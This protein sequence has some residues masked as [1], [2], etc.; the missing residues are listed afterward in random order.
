[1][2]ETSVVATRL[3][4]TVLML[5][6]LALCGVS[7]G[8]GFKLAPA[9]LVFLG[10]KVFFEF[11]DEQL[12]IAW[13]MLSAPIILF[14]FS[15]LLPSFLYVLLLEDQGKLHRSRGY[16]LSLLLRNVKNII[17]EIDIPYFSPVF[18]YNSID[19]FDEHVKEMRDNYRNFVDALFTGIELQATYIRSPGIATVP[20]SID[21][22]VTMEGIN[23]KESYFQLAK[24]SRSAAVLILTTMLVLFMGPIALLFGGIL[25]LTTMLDADAPLE[26]GTEQGNKFKDGVYRITNS[27]YGIEI[28]R[29]IGVAHGGVM[30]I[31]YHVCHGSRLISGKS[32]TG[33]YQIA[34][35]NDIVTYGGPPNMSQ[36]DSDMMVYANCETDD[37]RVS[38][39]VQPTV[40]IYRNV[41]WPSM[42]KPGESGSPLYAYKD[43]KLHLLGLCGRY[44]QPSNQEAIEFCPNNTIIGE[45]DVERIV[46]HPGSGKTHKTLPNII[47]ARLPNLRGKKILV[48]GPTRVVCKEIANSL[49]RNFVVGVNTSD[50]IGEVKTTAQVQVAAHATAL[51]MLCNEDRIMKNVGLII[52]DEAH[53]NDVNTI[54]LRKYAR[55][56]GIKLVEMSA[57][58]DGEYA[59]DSNQP[60]TD[61]E[62]GPNKLEATLSDELNLGHRVMV[63]VSGVK[64]RM[65]D[66]LMFKYRDYSPIILSRATL[67]PAMA[68]I[69]ALDDDNRYKSRLII[70]TDIAEC[71]INIPDLDVVIDLM[72]K[73]TYVRNGCIISG[74]M[75]VPSR[76]SQ[77]QRRGRVGRVKK[78][79]YYYTRSPVDTEIETAAEFDATI[80]AS[81]RS[82]GE[83]QTNEW[84]IKLTD[85]QFLKWLE[86]DETPLWTY[87][88]TGRN[89][90]RLNASQL[91][92][93][94][95]DWKGPTIYTG[96]SN[97]QCP[98]AGSYETYDERNHDKMF[99]T[100]IIEL[101]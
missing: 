96:C 9:I 76:A 68:G 43:E 82:W 89:G 47:A 59:T 45:Q 100:P 77:I 65:V 29:G 42:T 38:Y 3:H 49:K 78:G 17:N 12:L 11:K 40:D 44:Y 8:M 20:I 33:P 41:M 48:T 88:S 69:M 72:E 28:S 16:M 23:I 99:A 26:Y 5:I 50:A 60:I 4:T 98:C 87:L 55:G 31:P 21:N 90:D 79:K 13:R 39:Q 83:G 15:S 97:R 61:I 25:Y 92:D 80:L 6:G 32:R 53:T 63:F 86:S 64:G 94:L 35:E 37:A 71:G 70:S 75:I 22:Q 95:N 67:K 54:L 27:I 85:R 7:D 52:I 57:T 84:N 81:G 2:N 30:H 51:R 14:G 93:S 56:A 24:F 101:Y 58:L 74:Q 62:L 91:R 73:F 34:R 18:G 1:M 66:N 19:I 46:Q 36:Y 10:P